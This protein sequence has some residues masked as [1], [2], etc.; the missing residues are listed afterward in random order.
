VTRSPQK[1][2]TVTAV[3]P[4]KNEAKNLPLV[5]PKLVRLV[6]EVILVDASSSDATVEIARALVPDVVVVYQRARGKGSALSAGFAAASG[7]LVVML[8]ADGSMDPEEIPRFTAALLSDADVVKGSRAAPGGG[9]H[10]LTLLRRVGNA[11]LR[12]MANLLFRQRW[13]ELAYG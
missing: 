11:A 13:T 8:D 2:V 12:T 3:V 6:D 10:D 9:S 5:L 4:T 1:A 7:D